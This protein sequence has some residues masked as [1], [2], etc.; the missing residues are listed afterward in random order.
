MFSPPGLPIVRVAATLRFVARSAAGRRPKP[1]A[2]PQRGRRQPPPPRQPRPEDLMFFPRLRN[3]AKWMF[4]FLALVFGVG[5]VIFGVG[6][7]LPSGVA[8]LIRN[9]GSSTA[10]SVSDA[11]DKIDKS[12]KDATAQVELSRAY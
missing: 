12:P 6:S 4:V 11:Q 2:T 7:S 1:V 10:A 9:N 5:F 3:H 8:D